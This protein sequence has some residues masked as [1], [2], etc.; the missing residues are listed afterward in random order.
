MASEIEIGILLFRYF[1]YIMLFSSLHISFPVSLRTHPKVVFLLH[2][3]NE[4]PYRTV[5]MEARQ[6]ET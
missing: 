5:R 1:D 2:Y 4:V 6:I 3:W